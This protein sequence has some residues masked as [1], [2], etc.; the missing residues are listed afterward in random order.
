MET[1]NQTGQLVPLD[2]LIE[3]EHNP[4]NINTVDF[5]RLKTQ[6]ETLGMYKPLLAMPQGDTF[7]I[8]GGNMRLKALQELKPPAVWISR[9][10]IMLDAND[11]VWHVFI[12]GKES[13]KRFQQQADAMMEYALSDND[14]AGYYD[15]S[16]LANLIPTV[17]VDWS[18]YAADLNP[19][20]NLQDIIDKF[21]E[22]EAEEDEAPEV[23]SEPPI[24][25]LGEV[26]Q[27]GRWIYCPKCKKKHHLIDVR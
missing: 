11:N 6:I 21:K 12:N 24:S 8:L 5:A 25:K 20:T 4:R 17:N 9:V 22:A 27:L 18:L 10:D 1:T 23:S 3:W 13:P 14:R 2:K 15:D 19:P 7:V 16:L 26:Y